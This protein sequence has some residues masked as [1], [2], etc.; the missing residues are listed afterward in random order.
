MLQV[1]NIIKEGI[2]YLGV[3]RASGPSNSNSA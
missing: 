3:A 2:R 1:S